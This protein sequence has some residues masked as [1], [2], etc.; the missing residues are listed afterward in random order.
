MTGTTGRVEIISTAGPS[1]V[2]MASTERT[3]IAGSVL[4]TNCGLYCARA[5]EEKR[6]AGNMDSTASLSP[7]RGKHF[8]FRGCCYNDITGVGRRKGHRGPKVTGS[9]P[10]RNGFDAPRT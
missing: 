9:L 10:L 2:G 8:I 7:I 6:R 3:V 5:N 4:A 1:D